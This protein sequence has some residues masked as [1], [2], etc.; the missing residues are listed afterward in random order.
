MSDKRLSVIVPVYN[1]E[2]SLRETLKSLRKQSIK[3]YE[4]IVVDDCS[5]DNSSNI[6]KTYADK[7][8]RNKTNNGPAISRNKGIKK[9]KGDIIAFIDSDCIADNKWVEN[10]L[11]AFDTK[12]IDVLMGNTKIPKSNFIGDCI[13]ELGFPGGANAGFQNIWHV[14]KK[15]F[16][17][18]ITSCNFAVRKRIFKEHG[19]FD[20]SFPLAGGEDPELSYRWVKS[21][22]KIKYSSNVLVWHE[23]RKSL[24]SFIS[25]MIYRGRCNYYFKQK[26]GKIGN[27]VKLRLWSSKN[28]IKKNLLSKK[29]LLIPLLL[30][31]SLILQ[32]Y[33]FFLEKKK[34]IKTHE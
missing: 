14:S 13:S 34:A 33:G 2:K 27:F 8:I 17:N 1:R 6:A 16:T 19:A 25:W 11:R 5:T 21:G 29:I 4:I 3:P 22:V 12:N 30:F 28:I 10:I 9:A 20:E 31:L 23:P 18:H 15:G 32:Q 26:V 7:I 24:R